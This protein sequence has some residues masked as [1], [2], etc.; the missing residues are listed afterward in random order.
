[1]AGISLGLPIL[2]KPITED[3]NVYIQNESEW[4]IVRYVLPKFSRPTAG[5]IRES[6]EEP[7]HDE[8]FSVL[9]VLRDKKMTWCQALATCN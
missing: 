9:R 5:G 3:V 1:M 7:V 4:E 2:G 8:F 6:D